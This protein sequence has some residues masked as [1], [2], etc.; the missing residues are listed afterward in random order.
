MTICTGTRGF[1]A[2]L[3]LALSA[4]V[5]AR[6]PKPP[7]LAIVG[8]TVVDPRT[9]AAHP[10]QTVLVAGERILAVGPPDQVAVP[11]GTP[12]VDATGRFLIPGLWDMHVHALWDPTVRDTFLTTL[13]AN[14]VTGVRDMGGTL[15]V[16]AQVRAEQAATDP[17]WPTIVAAGP[18][19]DGPQPVDPSIS[20]AIETPDQAREAVAQ[21]ANAGVD[22]IKV[23]TLLSPDAYRATVTEA[24][25]LGLP[26]AGHIPYG[27]SVVE[28]ST[29]MRSVEHLR[30]ETGGLCAE[31]SVEDCEAGYAAL[32]KHG[33]WQTPTL[34]ARRPRA[35][36]DDAELVDDPRLAYVPATL[37][38]TWL[39]NHTRNAS[40]PAEQRHA[41]RDA[42]ARE[43]A[44]A[45]AL[46]ERGLHVLAGSDAGAD[47]ALPGFGLHDELALLVE[48]GLTPAQALQGATS[49][50]A[51]YLQRPH[52][53]M[54]AP[55]AVADL[56]LLDANPLLDIHNTTRIR[57]VVLRGR[58]L[59]R[60][61]LD[62]LLQQARAA[63]GER[64]K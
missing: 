58:L 33:V 24:S 20:L 2:F 28:A 38:E 63:A 45:G 22:F 25:R 59:D 8:A 34:V 7:D 21:L 26:V 5:H 14:G 23:Y 4:C 31:L 32:R 3:A 10:D 15:E 27:V 19:L 49:E 57:A 64:V 37:R 46:P 53:G 30:A 48:A 43:Q 6:L 52:I 16:L 9:A 50:A 39:A 18:I 55:G 13:V 17:P 11:P 51:D 54:I 47:F 35:V 56:V 29:G 36:V 62:G 12:R 42:F 44:D 61:A 1:V 60:D 40:R 41:R